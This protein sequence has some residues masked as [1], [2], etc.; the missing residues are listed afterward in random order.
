MGFDCIIIS[1]KDSADD[2][3]LK[4]DYSGYLE[5]LLKW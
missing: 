4:L 3:Y 1:L 2:T 5:N